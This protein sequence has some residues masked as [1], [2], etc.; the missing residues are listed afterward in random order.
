[1]DSSPHKKHLSPP[2][3]SIRAGDIGLIFFCL[4][5]STYLFKTLWHTEQATK[6]QVK[7]GSQIVGTYSLNQSR[8]IHLM[9]AIGATHISIANGKVRF[10]SAPCSNQYCVHQGWLHHTG[11]AAICLPNQISV[12]L[13]GKQKPFDTLNY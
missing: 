6:V 9:G 1:M 5:V 10:T 4:L 12:E 11:Q 8:D 3:V 13:L 7:Y 2:R